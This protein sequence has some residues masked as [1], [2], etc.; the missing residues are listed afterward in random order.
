MVRRTGTRR[1]C[2]SDMIVPAD[3]GHGDCASGSYKCYNT[4]VSPTHSLHFRRRLGIL[5]NIV[6]VDV[7]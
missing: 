4:P 2:N 3:I 6:I 7:V 1:M 5:A